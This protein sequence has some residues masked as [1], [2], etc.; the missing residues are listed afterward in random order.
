MMFGPFDYFAPSL[1]ELSAPIFAPSLVYVPEY[2]PIY[3][4]RHDTRHLPVIAAFARECQPS[5][6]VIDTVSS[7][8]VA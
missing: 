7:Y 6:M 3:R 5:E 1:V 8:C 2:S 4:E